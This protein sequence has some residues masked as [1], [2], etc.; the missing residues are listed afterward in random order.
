MHSL[1][2]PFLPPL[3][4]WHS[5]FATPAHM[6][7]KKSAFSLYWSRMPGLFLCVPLLKATMPACLPAP[8][9]SPVCE[10]PVPCLVVTKRLHLWAVTTVKM[11][12]CAHTYLWAGTQL[13]L[14]SCLNYRWLAH[15]TANMVPYVVPKDQVFCLL[16]P[17][18]PVY[19]LYSC[20]HISW[21]CFKL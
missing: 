4:T 9:A 20:S 15:H 8:T 16:N 10:L 12:S 6:G 14:D 2:C 17:E 19:L 7:E 21:L 5:S 11:F 18:P 1:P 13:P 3:R